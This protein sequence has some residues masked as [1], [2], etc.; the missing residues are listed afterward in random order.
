MSEEIVTTISVPRELWNRI[1][2]RAIREK[3]DAKDIVI[4]ALQKHMEAK[5]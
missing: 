3:C 5:A 4:E 2:I 1:K